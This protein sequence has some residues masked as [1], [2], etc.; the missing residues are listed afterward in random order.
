[1]KIGNGS[2]LPYDRTARGE[3]TSNGGTDGQGF[4]CRA[5]Y[6]PATVAARSGLL[7]AWRQVELP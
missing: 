4:P 7:H 3:K 5:T 1:M 6:L 2:E